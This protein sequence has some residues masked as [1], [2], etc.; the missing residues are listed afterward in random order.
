MP[1]PSGGPPPVLRSAL[2]SGALLDRLENPVSEHGHFHPTTRSAHLGDFVTVLSQA[3]T[4]YRQ[5]AA[6]G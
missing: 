5:G 4:F 3:R 6:E 1:E 2:V